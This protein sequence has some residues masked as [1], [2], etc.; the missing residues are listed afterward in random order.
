MSTLFLPKEQIYKG[1]LILVNRAHPYKDD[2]YTDLVA[3]AKSGTP[4]QMQR[5]A[6]RMLT[7]LLQKIEGWEHIV[8]VSGWRSAAEQQS[9]WDDSIQSNGAAFTAK[10]V[11]LPG[12]SEHQTGLAIDLGQKKKEIDFLRPAF[13]Y[14]GIFQTF[15]MLAAQYGFIERYPAGKESITQ[16]GHEPWHFRYVGVPHAGIIC[17]EGLT[18]EEYTDFIRRYS[19]KSPYIFD[20]NGQ[21]IR[22]CYLPA[23]RIGE[24]A[25]TV[26][27][28]AP[29]AISG[30]NVNGFVLTQWGKKH[31]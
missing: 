4:V 29:Y 26:P 17:K 23:A 10:Y 7:M 12:C 9:I 31:G 18:L 14:T 22:V 30:N 16:I 6:G 21:E 3:V 5:R 19:C 11:A 27:E 2:A 20:E 24:T 25:C 13:P 8:P 28:G 15:R 1:E